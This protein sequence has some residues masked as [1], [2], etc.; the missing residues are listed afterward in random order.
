[1][2]FGASGLVYSDDSTIF[3]L[4]HPVCNPQ[5]FIVFAFLNVFI[6]YFLFN[7][8]INIVFF[9]DTVC[10]KNPSATSSIAPPTTSSI[11]P[12]PTSTPAPP[13][14]SVCVSEACL[15]LAVQI[16]I[17]KAFVWLSCDA[18]ELQ[19]NSLYA[20]LVVHIL[21]VTIVGIIH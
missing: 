6:S 12:S 5:Q 16:I 3:G 8:N 14:P 2:F 17:S 18:I 21:H 4:C 11:A 1:M 7:L 20:S 9:F 13:P 10:I 15:D 19:V